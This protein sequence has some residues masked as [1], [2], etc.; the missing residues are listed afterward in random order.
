M[1]RDV[2]LSPVVR[3]LQGRHVN[4]SLTKEITVKARRQG[5]WGLVALAA[6]LVAANMALA[7]G[8]PGSQ[9]EDQLITLES[10]TTPVV[11]ILEILAER[12]GLN[13]VTAPEVQG[14][15]IS[16]RLRNTPFSEALNLVVRAAGLGYERVG[17]SILVAD[18]ERLATQ[19][20]LTT[21]VFTLQYANAQEV[22]AALDIISEEV[23][24]FISGNRIVVRAPQSAIE[25][26]D[27][28]I[29][30]I[31]L[32]PAQV[33]FEA[34]LVEVNTSA[35]QELGI[36]W[37]KITKW[38]EV[39][40]EGDAEES[41]ADA[42]PDELGFKQFDEFGTVHRQAEAVEVAIDLLLTEG[43][44]RLL[45]NSK[46]TTM[47][48]QPAEIF[49]GQTI[50]VVITSLQSGQ[51]GGTFQSVQL[52]YID[53]GVKLNILPRISAEGFITSVVTPEVSTIVGFVG[54][55]NDLPQTSTRRATSVVRVRD[56][57]K[58]YLGGLLNE[59]DRETTKK[60]PILGDIP[61]IRYLFRHYRIESTQT[62]LLIEITPTIVR[63]QG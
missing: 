46:I 45:A 8:S 29:E 27:R 18:P 34:R 12:T 49:I 52:D 9:P 53:V 61:L 57:Q 31:D 40:V 14:R 28:I 3:G 2:H 10:D 43:D 19:T 41:D 59:E 58:F 56:G 30:Q 1:A 60:V 44:A 35:L 39:L 23:R 5:L 21:R 33:L 25:E 47:D 7:Q 55:D 63:D 6:V 36:D 20:G 24:S 50:P 26:I 11:T 62:D 42:I 32:R 16:I 17:N 54:P 15:A 48:N 38:T 51:T 37:E 22:V 13:I 4:H